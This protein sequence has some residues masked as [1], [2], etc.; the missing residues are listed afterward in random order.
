MVI[1]RHGRRA[2]RVLRTTVVGFVCLLVLLLLLGVGCTGR[3]ARNGG[4]RTRVSGIVRIGGA[5]AACPL[6]RVLAKDFRKTHPSV[7]VIFL[8][9]GHCSGGYSGPKSGDFD[10]GLAARKPKPAELKYGVRI[11]EVCTDAVALAVNRS[12]GVDGL[13]PTQLNMIYAGKITNWKSVG[14]ASQNIVVLDRNG[15]ACARTALQKQIGAFKLGVS[16]KAIPLYYESEMNE[17]ISKTPGAIGYFSFGC[18][19]LEGTR[20]K[21]LKLAGVAPSADHLRDGSYRCRRPFV[22]VTRRDAPPQV[23]ELVAYF[24]GARAAQIME[25]YGFAPSSDMR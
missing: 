23:R 16:R 22:V 24:K 12:A 4:K 15:D 20:T 7:D 3:V 25:K 6:F 8:A 21:I 2:R 9:E 19:Q 17:V 5:S 10:V 14:G 13:T 18:A 1:C 11:E